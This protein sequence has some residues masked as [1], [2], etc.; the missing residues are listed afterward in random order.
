M[1]KKGDLND[2]EHGVVVGASLAGL[3]ISK[4]AD[5][6]KFSPQNHLCL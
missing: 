4:T 3:R 2:T 1:R 5:V 6:L